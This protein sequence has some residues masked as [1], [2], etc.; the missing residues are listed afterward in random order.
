LVSPERNRDF[1]LPL[2]DN[3]LGVEVPRVDSSCVHKAWWAEHELGVKALELRADFVLSVTEQTIFGPA[4]FQWTVCK[5]S[6]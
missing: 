1:A 3:F 2:A 6:F 4:P 5:L